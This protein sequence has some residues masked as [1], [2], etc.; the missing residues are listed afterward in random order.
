[1]GGVRLPR[2]CSGP[3]RAAVLLRTPPFRGA[4]AAA[5]RQQQQRRQRR[6]RRQQHPVRGRAGGAVARGG[7]AGPAQRGQGAPSRTVTPSPA[8]PG[9]EGCALLPAVHAA[10]RAAWPV[11]IG[12]GTGTVSDATA[13]AR[14]PGRSAHRSHAARVLVR[15]LVPCRRWHRIRPCVPGWVGDVEAAQVRKRRRD[16]DQAAARGE[17]GA[18][19]HAHVQH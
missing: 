10:Q 5:V 13:S 16:S 6:R 9:S 17:L 3:L 8:G 14:H 11:G 18:A 1:M 4:V 19:E 2:R 15:R 12:G 7:A